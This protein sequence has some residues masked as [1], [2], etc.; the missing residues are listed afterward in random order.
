ML[1]LKASFS[2]CLK[3]LQNPCAL[4]LGRGFDFKGHGVWG[5][6]GLCGARRRAVVVVRE[7]KLPCA[8]LLTA[9]GVVVVVVVVAR[10]AN[11]GRE[12]NGAQTAGTPARARVATRI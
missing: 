8:P 1:S 4:L 5:P 6:G 11:E 10:R 9:A 7:T 3:S 12:A 2:Q